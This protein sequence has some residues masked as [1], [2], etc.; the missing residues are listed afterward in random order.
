[1]PPRVTASCPVQPNVNDA[2]LSSAVDGVP[3]K[4]KVTLVSSVFVNAAPVISEPEIAD[5]TGAADTAPVP[6]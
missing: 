3:P 6:V 2:A 1:M 4:V 5:Q